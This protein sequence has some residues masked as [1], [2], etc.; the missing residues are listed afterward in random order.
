MNLNVIPEIL[1]IQF[2]ME[3]EVALHSWLIYLTLAIIAAATPGPAIL[4]ITT[5]ATLY[6]CR[7]AV[8][9]ALGNIFGLFC[10]GIITI[11]GLGVVLDT[12]VFIFNLVR[13][14]GAAYLI[15]LGIRLFFQKSGSFSMEKNK[16]IA[17]KV[18]PVR[19]FVQAFGVAVSNP[20]AIIFLTALF[21]QFVNIEEPLL[22]QFVVLISTLMTVSFCFLMF[23]GFLARKAKN[24][25]NMSN[26]NRLI[27]RTSGALFMG[28]GVILGV[29]SGR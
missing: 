25:L 29:S 22:F 18:S 27:S 1:R 21:P 4:L 19:L 20:K 23:Y 12:S 6:G 8:Y 16:C 10:M 26:R 2:S 13:Y 7:K 15:Y 14:I 3:I 28:I 17:P 9:T 5:N 24:W 11:S